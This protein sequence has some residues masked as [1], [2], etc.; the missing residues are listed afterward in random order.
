MSQLKTV[1]GETL[2][3]QNGRMRM[4]LPHR[5]NNHLRTLLK[6]FEA[7]ILIWGYILAELLQ[8]TY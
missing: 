6:I 5:N 8:K 3:C 1:W 2:S 4:Y 7:K